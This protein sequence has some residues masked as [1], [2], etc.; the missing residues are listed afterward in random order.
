MNRSISMMIGK[1]SV[2]HNS[3]KFHAENTDPERSHLN[4]VYIDEPIKD[5]YNKLF[6]EATKRYNDK[7]TRNDRRINDYYEKIRTGKQEKLFK[8]VIFQIGNKDDTGVSSTDAEKAIDVLDEYAKTFQE[9]NPNL[10]MFSAHLH[11]DEATPHLHIDFVPFTTG[12]TRGLET[13][14]S[15]KGALAAQ[16]I[17]GDRRQETEWSKWVLAEKE[18]M[19]KV[20]ERHGITWEKLGT[21]DEHLSVLNYKKE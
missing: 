19:S 14:V 16:G 9:R 17:I 5:V 1:G 6:E 3:R 12:S 2:N 15:L 13:R 4:R 18:W 8:E 10:Y 11:L 20:M 7:Q 21:N